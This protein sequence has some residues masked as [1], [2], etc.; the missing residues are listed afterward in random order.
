VVTKAAAAAAEAAYQVGY[1][2]QDII[3]NS[4]NDTYLFILDQS[5]DRRGQR[6]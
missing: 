6:E 3:F 2:I 4:D 5:S 1:S